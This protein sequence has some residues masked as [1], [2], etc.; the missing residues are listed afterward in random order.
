MGLAMVRRQG[1]TKPCTCLPTPL[2]LR[3][4]VVLAKSSDVPLT[5]GA[6]LAFSGP[7]LPGYV[8]LPGRVPFEYG[9]YKCPET[10]M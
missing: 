3:P 2:C 5:A 1:A 4:P 8:A 7:Q 10:Q 6:P 9:S